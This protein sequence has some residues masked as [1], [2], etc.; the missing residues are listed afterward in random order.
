MTLAKPWL[1]ASSG[2]ISHL[3]FRFS[4]PRRKVLPPGRNRNTAEG[5]FRKRPHPGFPYPAGGPSL[6]EVFRTSRL[7]R[8]RWHRMAFN[9]RIPKTMAMLATSISGALGSGTTIG[10]IN[11]VGPPLAI[12]GNGNSG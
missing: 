1:G 10:G 12:G 7:F 6:E 5:V 4:K 2:T 9:R 8:L 11:G 3:P